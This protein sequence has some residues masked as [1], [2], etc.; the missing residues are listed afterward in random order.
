MKNL[1]VI[2]S[3]FVPHLAEESWVYAGFDGLAC[4]QSWPEFDESLTDNEDVKIVVQINGKTRGELCLPI[5][6]EEKKA[7]EVAKSNN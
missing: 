4:K 2:L 6:D 5:S 7:V 3:P 1:I